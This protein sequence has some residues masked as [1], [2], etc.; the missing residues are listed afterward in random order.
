MKSIIYFSLTL[1]LAA[2]L[3]QT[4]DLPRHGML[5]VTVGP[6]DRT[7]PEDP[8]QNPLTI[9]AVAQDSAAAASGIQVGDTVRALDD[10]PVATASEFNAMVGRHLAGDQVTIKLVHAG[11]EIS[12]TVTLKPR[13]LETSPDAD[14]LYRSV[15]VDGARRRVIVTRPKTAGRYPA[16][17]IMGGLGCYSLDG[18]LLRDRGYGPILS[19][20][21]KHNV[22]TMRVEKTGEGDSEG[23]A[24]TDLKATAELEA[25]GYVAGLRALKSYDFVDPGKICVFAHS[26]GPLIGSLVVPQEPVHGFI[27]AE[28]IGRSWFEYQLE[29]VRR[30]FALA[31]KP[32]DEVDAR[33]RS[34][35]VC[36]H[37][38]FVQH[39]TPEKVT[40]LNPVCAEMIRSYAGVPYTYMQQI[41]DVSLG[42]QW[43][44]VDIPVLVIY[45]TSDPATSADESHY[46][47]NLINSFHPGRATYAELPGMA[48]VFDLYSSQAEFLIRGKD[49]KPHPYDQDVLAVIWKWIEEHM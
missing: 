45:G 25:R 14:V 47:V 24:C 41:G 3:A 6:A 35:E 26:L 15:V 23:P 29:N 4:D 5:G 37:H 33:V 42:K 10:R 9:Q 44:Q 16:V 34:D 48:H 46:L 7:K 11:E 38:F 20:L 49:Q 19:M 40:K 17:I 12:K 22:V 36:A 27:A 31:G 28:T 2:G 32:L 18:E 21:A 39:E 43:K 1:F 30:Q 13:P 8:K